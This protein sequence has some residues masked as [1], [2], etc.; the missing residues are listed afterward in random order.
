MEKTCPFSQFKMRKAIDKM[1]LKCILIQLFQKFFEKPFL[2][3]VTFDT[4]VK[5]VADLV[6]ARNAVMNLLML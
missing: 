1:H 5:K 6:I 2:C 3:K 4:F